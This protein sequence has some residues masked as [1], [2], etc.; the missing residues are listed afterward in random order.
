MLFLVLHGK[1]PTF[2]VKR[3]AHIAILAEVGSEIF[4]KLN[5]GRVCYFFFKIWHV[6]VGGKHIRGPWNFGGRLLI[7]WPECI[8]SK[9]VSFYIPILFGTQT[10]KLERETSTWVPHSHSKSALSDNTH[11]HCMCNGDLFGEDLPH[12]TPAKSS[13]IS[14][15]PTTRCRGP[16]NG[17]SVCCI[18]RVSIFSMDRHGWCLLRTHIN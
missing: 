10:E 3:R 6:G 15:N 9:Y 16:R 2:F 17:T 14:S 12:N 11:L 5:H 13:R 8:S 4:R 7:C 1:S 18:S